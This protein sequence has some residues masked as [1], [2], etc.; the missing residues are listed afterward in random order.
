MRQNCTK[1]HARTSL[2]MIAKFNTET[3]CGTYACQ[4]IFMSVKYYFT[5]MIILFRFLRITMMN[6]RYGVGK[7]VRRNDRPK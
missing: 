4:N 7:L 2:Y 6:L 3:C 5:D 1:I